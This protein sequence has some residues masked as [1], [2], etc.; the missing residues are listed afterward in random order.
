MTLRPA[1]SVAPDPGA[2]LLRGAAQEGV[3]ELGVGQALR[4]LGAWETTGPPFIS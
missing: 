1:A 4:G 2:E 3:E